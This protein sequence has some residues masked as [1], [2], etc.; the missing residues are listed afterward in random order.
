MCPYNQNS[1]ESY[2]CQEL[3]VTEFSPIIEP[4]VTYDRNKEFSHRL[5]AILDYISFHPKGEDR[6]G[7]LG[8][9]FGVT[10][11]AARKWL[12]EEGF[13]K[14]ARHQEIIEKL[15]EKGAQV[16]GEW[17][18]YGDQTKAPPWYKHQ[19]N[20]N[21]VELTNNYTVTSNTAEGPPIKGKIPLI[22]YVQAGNWVEIMESH[23]PMEWIERTIEVSTKAFALRVV[24]DSMTNPF[25]APSL[26]E[27]FIAIVEPEAQYT[28]GSIVVARLENSNEAMIKQLIIDGPHRYLKPLNP[29]YRTIEINENCVICGVVKRAQFDL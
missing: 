15:N 17:L 14:Q 29:N 20:I 11:K 13:P 16:S 6:Q 8:K 19:M 23:E 1:T 7:Q 12:E 26:P 18:F 24:G 28:S 21:D 27:G 2:L 9:L 10:Q 5:N 4:M 25:G 22:N 3:I